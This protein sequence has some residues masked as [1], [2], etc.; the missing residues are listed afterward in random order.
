MTGGHP[1]GYHMLATSLRRE[2]RAFGC[3]IKWSILLSLVVWG[4]FSTGGMGH[5][6]SGARFPRIMVRTYAIGSSG[7]EKGSRVIHSLLVPQL[8]D[9]VE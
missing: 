9:A 1:V 6:T 4:D 7:L 8:R 3:G 5:V 2:G